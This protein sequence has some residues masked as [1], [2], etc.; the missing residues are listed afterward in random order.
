MLGNKSFMRPLESVCF[1]HCD[2]EIIT[3]AGEVKVV[4]H[5]N[6]MALALL[7]YRLMT[8]IKV[9]AMIAGGLSLCAVVSIAVFFLASFFCAGINKLRCRPPL[10]YKEHKCEAETLFSA[11]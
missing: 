1:R 7:K 5:L 11:I 2:L 10:A 6:K 3:Q 8:D 4:E 9:F